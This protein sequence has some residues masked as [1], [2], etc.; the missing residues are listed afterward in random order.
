[1]DNLLPLRIVRGHVGE[2]FHNRNFL[3]VNLNRHRIEPL[4]RLKVERACEDATG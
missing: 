4:K 2:P 1:M 3:Q